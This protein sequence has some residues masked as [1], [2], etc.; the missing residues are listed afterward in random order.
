M[1][2]KPQKHKAENVFKHKTF[3]ERVAEIDVR[4][5]ILYHIDFR[6]DED[7]DENESYFAS[8]VTK[9]RALNL[10]DEYE[11]FHR[12]V[13]EI[14]T[15]PQLLHKK[16]FVIQHLL[17]CLAK[18]TQLSLQPLLEFVAILAK[19]LQS[20]FC[21]VLPQFLE[22]LL[23]LLQSTDP[24]IVEWTLICLAYLFKHLKKHLKKDIG[25]VLNLILPILKED[26][27]MNAGETIQTFAIECFA[28]VARDIRDREHFV[29]TVLGFVKENTGVSVSCSRLLFQV[30]RGV[31]GGLHSCTEDFLRVLLEALHSHE[32]DREVIYSLIDGIIESFDK[33]ISL[34]KTQVLWRVFMKH[35]MKLLALKDT[36]SSMSFCIKLVEK[37]V[38]GYSEIFLKNPQVLC[39]VA[40]KM[41]EMENENLYSPISGLTNALL[42]G[43]KV[44]LPIHEATNLSR[45]LLSMID[46][47]TVRNFVLST[48]NSPQFDS[49][50]FPNFLETFWRFGINEESLELLA[51]VFE[52]KCPLAKAGL[53]FSEWKPY[54]MSGKCSRV[55][56]EV[57]R[58]LLYSS[59]EQKI[60]FLA[61]LIWTHLAI[62][63]REGV[64]G[65]LLEE[66]KRLEN[67][68]FKRYSLIL[69]VLIHVK[70]DKIDAVDAVE[71]VL[72]FRDV[73]KVEVLRFVD[74]S[75]TSVKL[76][77]SSRLNMGLFEK[78]HDKLSPMLSSPIH[79]IRL[80]A[81]H[82]LAQFDHLEEFSSVDTFL[83]DLIFSVENTTASIQTYRSQLLSLQKLSV[84]TLYFRESLEKQEI[85]QW[86]GLKYLLGVLYINFKLLWEPTIEYIASYALNSDRKIFWKI[87]KDQLDSIDGNLR[88]RAEKC[89]D[90]INDILP[91]T[92]KDSPEQKI[93][94]RD[95]PDFINYRI[96][97]W[98]ALPGFG[99]ILKEKNRDLVIHFLDFYEKVYKVYV[100]EHSHGK[101]DVRVKNDEKELEL[102]E[103][104]PEEDHDPQVTKAIHKEL[105][106]YLQVF[107]AMPN[108]KSIFRESEM[109]SI[110]LHLLSSRNPDVQKTALDCLFAYKPKNLSA[111]RETLYNFV[112]EKKLRV[113]MGNFVINLEQKD[114]ELSIE[115]HRADVMDYLLRILHGKMFTRQQHQ[116][117]VS[118]LA[119]KTMIIRYLSGC[120]PEE[121]HKFLD[122]IFHTTSGLPI[123]NPVDLSSVTHPRH[124]QSS[125]ALIDL[126]LGEFGGLRNDEILR[127]LLHLLL[128]FSAEIQGI[129][130]AMDGGEIRYLQLLKN[131]RTEAVNMI[132]KFFNL[133]EAYP[134]QE[135]EIEAVFEIFI[136]PQ[137]SKLPIECI[138]SPTPLLKL[139][140]AWSTNP[141]YFVL[142]SK[143]P[144][145]NSADNPLK[146]V[147]E[148]LKKPKINVKVT[149][150]ALE[151]ISNLLTL[152]L[153]AL[154]D[155]E[156][157]KMAPEIIIKNSRIPQFETERELS[158]GRK[159]ILPHIDDI[160][161]RLKVKVGNQKKGKALGK[162]DLSILS[163]ITDLVEDREK[164]DVLVGLLLPILTKKTTRMINESSM[165]QMITSLTHLIDKSDTPGRHIRTLAPLFEE[166][167][168]L[169]CRKLLCDL[170]G[171][172]CERS[173]DRKIAELV[174]E[175]NALSKRWIDQPDFDRR[176]T[177]FRTIDELIEKDAVDAN[178]GLLA[179]FHAFFFLRHEKDLAMRSSSS[180]CL[181]KMTLALARKFSEK[182]HERRY[183]FDGV[184][185]PQIKRSLS[186]NNEGL[187]TECVR[188]LGD[189]ARDYPEV[190]Y[191]FADL[192][193]LTD[194]QDKEVDF[195]E[196]IIHL[197]LHR[198]G[199]ALGRFIK[200][201]PEMTEP[202]PK[203]LMDFLL[204]LASCYLGSEKHI[205]NNSLVD[206]AAEAVSVI[207][208]KLP[209]LQ[210]QTILRL[211][212]RKLRTSVE[213]QKQMV[214]V[215][216]A[217]IDAFHFDFSGQMTTQEVVQETE[218][219]DDED[220][221][222]LKEVK[223][224]SRK[225]LMEKS[226]TNPEYNLMVGLI[227]S[228]I[229]TI[230]EFSTKES[231]H[232]LT[233][234]QNAAQKEE[235]DILRVPIAV[236]TVQ[237]LH[238]V[239]KDLLD[240]H[241]SKIFMKLCT[242]LKSRLKS[243]RIV[244]RDM[245]RR[246]MVILGPGYLKILLDLLTSLLTRGYQVHVLVVT[247]HNILDALKG[248]FRAGDI[249]VNLQGLLNVCLENV[250][251][252]SAEEREVD[253]IAAKT[254]EAKFTNK[255]FLIL[256]I[257]AANISEKCLLDL[258]V[259]FKDHLA[260][261]HSKKVVNKVQ[262]CL[263]RIVRGLGENKRISTD[264]LMIF[265]FG[266]VTDSIDTL[267]MKMTKKELSEVD[268]EL[269]RRKPSDIFLIV[270]E[271]SVSRRN[272]VVKTNVQTNTY[273]LTEFG[274]NLL[275]TILKSG[276]AD[277]DQFESFLNPLV[278][279]FKETL[280]GVHVRLSTLTLKCLT[281][282]WTRQLMRE[283]IKG[284]TIEDFVGKILE[285][286]KRY[287]STE[288]SKNDENFHLVKNTFK[289]IMALM[290]FVE[291]F[292][293][294]EDQL[295]EILLHVDRDL[296]ARQA[297]AFP[298]L[299]AILAKKLYVTEIEKIIEFV[300]ELSVTSDDESVREEARQIIITYLLDYPMDGSKFKQHLMFFLS[301]LTYSESTGRSS[302]VKLI[303][304]LVKKLS[305][306]TLKI[307]CGVIFLAL[308]ARF[309]EDELP[310]VREEIAK[311]L[312]GILRRLDDDARRELW[313]I[314][315]ALFNEKKTSHIEMGSVL[316]VRFMVAEGE[317]FRKRLDNLLPLMIGKLSGQEDDNVPG[318]FVR[319]H[320]EDIA[321]ESDESKARAN[322][323]KLIQILI[324]LGK[325]FG[326]FEDILKEEK[327]NGVIDSLAFK[328]QELLGYDHSWVRLFSAKIL[329]S[330]LGVVDVE[331]L[332]KRMVDP[333][334][335]SELS[336]EFLYRNP[337]SQIRALTLDLCAQLQPDH[338]QDNMVQEIMKILLEVA[339][340]IR[341]IPVVKKE[342]DADEEDTKVDN[343]INLLWIIRRLR[344]AA[345]GE[346]TQAPHS[347]VIRKNVF[348]WIQGIVH[349][350]DSPTMRL[351]ARSLLTPL[352]REIHT[353]NHDLTLNQIAT[354]IVDKIKNKM[355]NEAEFTGLVNEI[356]L[357]QMQKRSERK[358]I[359]AMEKV[360]NPAK[361]AK[362]K[363]SVQ[364]R[365]K[366]AK[367]RKMD[368]IKGK[369]A[370]KRRKTP[371][372]A[373]S[374]KK[375]KKVK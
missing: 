205:S 186:G 295:R 153:E 234:A 224:E 46:F 310:E 43:S 40:V 17:N 302:V 151:I 14:L 15:L 86:D 231:N 219:T 247:L 196:N 96:L 257:L 287:S 370:P 183:I 361:A 57:E 70:C 65:K 226:Q 195:F 140:L 91:M 87:Y 358:K 10:T 155:E 191:V 128:G 150:A 244:T 327:L 308:G 21:E 37:L 306:K 129:L 123:R 20:D 199:R 368:I 322:D 110:Y 154:A 90:F 32:G 62:R 206:V 131:I 181:K 200:R 158:I 51:T 138:H 66:M 74:L 3:G 299:R 360:T 136:W 256:H 194:K 85:F 60:F 5:A 279:I 284:Q 99:D 88:R 141:R 64:E 24:D 25:I 351:L 222:E 145:D 67:E 289:A 152:D 97:L 198:Q 317:A 245:L 263:T 362:R 375:R 321:V 217:I 103:E 50:I 347:T 178:L 366:L 218:E 254:P 29:K 159:L 248:S 345:N 318:R 221:E 305:K 204:P 214:K 27:G 166:I 258:L 276:R 271:K 329:G 41:L 149:D 6:F 346:V 68:D 259:P 119:R 281:V 293:V 291:D 30:I 363:A 301:Q 364:E 350:L 18:A 185:L 111:H 352:L 311:C 134:W 242:F 353:E 269:L 72:E 270:D 211:Y 157:A 137:L 180:H 81:S 323:H 192:H 286:L 240:T 127:R 139:F 107:T 325:I 342:K 49:L 177:A 108:P 340:F 315:V 303:Q 232:K 100:L 227:S 283:A 253:K 28:Y 130:T 261:S 126:M 165:V 38:C 335:E 172:I 324:A 320:V 104:D 161:S 237:L 122:M 164:C 297:I 341:L 78:L 176:L 210:Y 113:A 238:K 243:V 355:N 11:E 146:T 188:I 13:R 148:L 53:T 112:D 142:L 213:Y 82:I 209:F 265:T 105:I 201:A 94:L 332:R 331:L 330:I 354:K 223:K 8:A 316:T 233:K 79:E 160:I 326:Q 236:A 26:R 1:K 167:S 121:L 296:H 171:R 277:S 71:R 371:I 33:N 298:L 294:T 173:G 249:D 212:I 230:S 264:S 118:P 359:I 115:E 80:L 333:D 143:V 369:V 2:N 19:E 55:Q 132:R 203:T 356:Q 48:K 372:N 114:Q 373:N 239:S 69:R 170:I 182:P 235:E 98:R 193:P 120:S 35:L 174:Q 272:K 260:R 208:S 42:T 285:I 268:R 336:R 95:R 251:G 290:R 39:E 4:K 304:N 36:S 365:K 344:Y 147:F 262:E 9:W 44:N 109:H 89:R 255:S 228:L 275:H 77:D 207:C 63:D 252:E 52:V 307:N 12:G 309:V 58:I 343:R 314:V 246:I 288:L 225:F 337:E 7:L 339:K 278:R 189:L 54:G 45:K 292:T 163:R 22:Q 202:N 241:L 106:T 31:S 23:K 250:F 338:V 312:E 125:L 102:K 124:L 168:S 75:V 190:H 56:E 76:R 267:K 47:S 61:L 220:D 348:H 367:K 93:V 300:A 59:F 133:F 175:L 328:C 135:D 101:I 16:D 83:F 229:A 280:A 73:E 92:L 319:A 349:M 216:I 116:K 357:K 162:R 187:R 266:V 144:S 282:I 34:D 156:I 313:E 215:V 334:E 374:S 179:I 84:G 274:L 273:V 184:L 117:G 169:A 197:Q